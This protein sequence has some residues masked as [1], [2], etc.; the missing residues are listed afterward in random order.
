MK[1]I[2]TLL[3]QYSTCLQ[4]V[5]TMGRA[6]NWKIK[7]VNK[8]KT[9]AYADRQSKELGDLSN[10][11]FYSVLDTIKTSLIQATTS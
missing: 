10:P 8:G 3:E 9:G 1:S 4:T 6:L 5:P 11:N 7:K 2:F